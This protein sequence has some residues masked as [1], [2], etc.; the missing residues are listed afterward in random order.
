MNM[1]ENAIRI[2][3][4]LTASYIVSFVLVLLMSFIMYKMKLNEAQTYIGIIVIYV[5]SS[6]VGGFF[7][8]KSVKTKRLLMGLLMGMLYFLV[9]TVV[10]VIVNNGIHDGASSII[11]A[12]IACVAGGV[13]GGIAG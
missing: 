2:L 7:L 11:K 12:L 13:I 3:K 1:K 10:S 6:A 9:L 5:I 4:S 8:A